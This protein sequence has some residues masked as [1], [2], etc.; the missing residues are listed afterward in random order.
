MAAIIV[1]LVWLFIFGAL[2][3]YDTGRLD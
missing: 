1:I 2:N 3:T